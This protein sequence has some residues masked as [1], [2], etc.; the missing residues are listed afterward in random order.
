MTGCDR[1]VLMVAGAAA[2]G[3]AIWRAPLNAAFF[4]VEAPFRRIVAGRLLV[5][6]L[7]EDGAGYL[8]FVGIHGHTSL[9][10]VAPA[11]A[12]GSRELGG[13][14]LIGILT[15]LG[16]RGFVWLVLRARTIQ[17]TA[18]IPLRVAMAGL[19]F[20]ALAVLSYWM[21]GTVLT[22][23]PGISASAWAIGDWPVSLIA[24]V[25]LLRLL[26]TATAVGAGGAGGL[27][28]HS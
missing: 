5:P 8:A 28:T 1:R 22:L 20:A 23:G 13:A 6:A 26:A 7:A 18:P 14:V 9:F 4:V 27:T 19:A 17:T 10:S 11:A 24:A 16:A 25:I 2:G 15:A 12:L 21:A 3:A